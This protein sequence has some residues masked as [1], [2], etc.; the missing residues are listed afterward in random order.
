MIV[1]FWVF[2]FLFTHEG[3]LFSRYF[4]KETNTVQNKQ[5]NSIPTLSNPYCNRLYVSDKTIHSTQ[6][7]KIVTIPFGRL[8]GFLD[9]L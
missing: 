4:A 3:F 8:L 1:L 5:T 6:I 2:F 7:T 9:I